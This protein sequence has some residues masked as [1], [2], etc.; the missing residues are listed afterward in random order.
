[1]TREFKRGNDNLIFAKNNLTFE[2]A[3]TGY[4]DMLP[5]SDDDEDEV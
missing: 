5:S 3:D 4:K 1:M 2:Q